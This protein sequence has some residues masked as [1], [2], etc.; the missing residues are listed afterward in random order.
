MVKMVVFVNSDDQSICPVIGTVERATIHKWQTRLQFKAAYT[1]LDTH[2]EMFYDLVE[3]YKDARFIALGDEAAKELKMMRL[4]YFKLPNPS[5]RNTFL[6]NKVQ[7][8]AVLEECRK[9]LQK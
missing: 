5:P 6:K 4:E 1:T 2:N 9:W 7:V 8:D 3:K